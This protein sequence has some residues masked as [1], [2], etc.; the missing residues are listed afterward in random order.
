MCLARPSPWLPEGFTQN[1]WTAALP[2]SARG[3][4]G[5]RGEM[6]L[7][8]R[9]E[10]GLRRTVVEPPRRAILLEHGI[11]DGAIFLLLLLLMP[12]DGTES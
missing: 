2:L 9:S 5:R 11:S 12:V 1:V 3:R 10:P 6:L 4:L 7:L 8:E